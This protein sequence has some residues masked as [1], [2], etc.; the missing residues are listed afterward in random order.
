VILAGNHTYQAALALGWDQVAAITVELTGSEATGFALADNRLSDLASY[1]NDALLAM[2]LET[3]DLKGT[4]YDA[5]DLDALKYLLD[6]PMD[7]DSLYEEVGDVS[8]DDQLPRIVLSVTAK[9]MKAWHD[10]R[11]GHSTD[12]SALAAL[13]G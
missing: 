9:T 13:L 2:I 10:Y 5:D 4:G 1:D 8:R 11:N 6:E 3:G 7:L 12:D